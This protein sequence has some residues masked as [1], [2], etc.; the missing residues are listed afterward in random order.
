MSQQVEQA[1]EGWKEGK[2]ENHIQNS[3]GAPRLC[4]GSESHMLEL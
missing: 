1:G 3:N 2:G 4:Y